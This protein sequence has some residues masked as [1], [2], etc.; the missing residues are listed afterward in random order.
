MRLTRFA[1]VNYLMEKIGTFR[2]T[3][4][5]KF[6]LITGLAVNLRTTTAICF[7]VAWS[8]ATVA[9]FA[10]DN[11]R[12]LG[13]P[14]VKTD[15]DYTALLNEAK[16][17]AQREDF[18][19]AVE[20]Y[21]GL[22]ERGGDVVF[23]S[24]RGLYLPIAEGARRGIAELPE[25][26]LNLYLSLYEPV[27]QRA[28]AEAIESADL[29]ALLQT[30]SQYS[31]TASAA[32]AHYMAGVYY[33]DRGEFA[34]A[35]RYF[36]KALASPR[37]A[38]VNAALARARLAVALS[39]LSRADELAILEKETAA[40]LPN[41]TI[42]IGGRERS[43]VE[44]IK[45]QIAA[46][47]AIAGPPA[48]EPTEWRMQGGNPS[49][50]KLM[51]DSEFALNPQWVVPFGD[52]SYNP[53]QVAQFRQNF[54]MTQETELIPPALVIGNRVIV[55][56]WDWLYDINAFTGAREKERQEAR[57]DLSPNPQ[58]QIYDTNR[59][60]ISSDGAR[61][62]YLE[63]FPIAQQ[64]GVM[65]GGRPQPPAQARSNFLIARD[66]TTYKIVWRIG[67]ADETDEWLRAAIFVT[68]PTPSEGRLFALAEAFQSLHLVCLDA[69]TGRVLWKSYLSSL[70]PRA[71]SSGMYGYVTPL[72]N[73]PPAVSGDSVV[74]ITNGGILASFDR[75]TG[76]VRWVVQYPSTF[77]QMPEAGGR[78]LGGRMPTPVR[79]QQN[80]LIIYND[81]IYALPADSD[82]VAAYD[83]DTGKT[84]WS[85][86]RGT[87]QYLAGISKD[88]L[89]LVGNEAVCLAARDGKILWRTRDL[90]GIAQGRPAMSE[91]YLYVSQKDQGVARVDLANGSTTLLPLGS[92]SSPLG[93]LVLLKDKLIVT[94][95]LG[96]AAYLSYEG[97]FDNATKIIA[98][99]ANDPAKLPELYRQRAVVSFNCLRYDK[100]I[101]DF[102][103]AADLARAQQQTDPLREY[104]WQLTQAHVQLALKLPPD[105][106]AEQ[107]NLAAAVA[108]DSAFADSDFGARARSEVAFTA[109]IFHEAA[110]NHPHAVAA[111]QE[112]LDSIPE[113]TLDAPNYRVEDGRVITG[114]ARITTKN[115]DFARQEIGRLIK[116][117]GA[118]IYAAQDAAAKQLRARAAAA[119]N[120]PQLVEVARRYPFSS[121]ADGALQDAA[122]FYFKAQNYADAEKML[123]LWRARYQPSTMPPQLLAALALTYEN[124]KRDLLAR[125]YVARL[126]KHPHDR[127]IQFAN[128]RGTVGNFLQTAAQRLDLDLTRL[129]TTWTDLPGDLQLPLARGGSQQRFNQGGMRQ[130]LVDT[131]STPVIHNDN[132]IMLEPP[133][134]A[135]IAALNPR[136][137]EPQWKALAD[138]NPA[139]FAVAR[140]WPP[141]QLIS[142]IY[143]DMLV[144]A[145]RDK[146]VGI[147]AQSGKRQWVVP[148]Q[149]PAQNASAIFGVNHVFAT[150]QLG[151]ITAIDPVGGKRLWE[152]A[153]RSPSNFLQIETGAEHIAVIGHSQVATNFIN[154]RGGAPAHPRIINVAPQPRAGIGPSVTVVTCISTVTGKVTGEFRV[155]SSADT[156]WHMTENDQLI[157]QG[158]NFVRCYSPSDGKVLWEAGFRDGTPRLL[159][160]SEEFAICAIDSQTKQDIVA[161]DL[162]SGK[163]RWRRTLED[164]GRKVFAITAVVQRDQVVILGAL[165]TQ[166]ISPQGG[167][168]RLRRVVNQQGYTVQGPRLA[169]IGLSDGGARHVSKLSANVD[170]INWQWIQS[171]VVTENQ[172]VT[173]VKQQM[174]AT[175][176]LACVNDANSGAL[177]QEISVDDAG[178]NQPAANQP[179][180][181]LGGA[182]IIRI[183]GMVGNPQGFHSAGNAAVANGVL[184]IE[185][186]NDIVTFGSGK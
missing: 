31:L 166:N 81:A 2:K 112:I 16:K 11:E 89:V 105:Q 61:V 42:K 45:E 55:R 180:A 170:D 28:V 64:A 131:E 118:T 100:A 70:P 114:M 1:P 47:G 65:W 158:S 111:L 172:I 146:V 32:R 160:A 9:A 144:V 29:A 113:V 125:R 174:G 97:A 51:A 123:S 21:Q 41:A 83:L 44:F 124:Q 176:I 140:Q 98:A 163:I 138:F 108:K 145:D 84:L 147:N 94:T 69:E 76:D 25:K 39:R 173:V 119:N 27:A 104:L 141:Q 135:Q 34:L 74:C 12:P 116:A 72:P 10:Q 181:V 185:G 184:V 164:K 49:G 156:Q 142:K 152:H 117:H 13:L 133:P 182:A 82:T 85:V 56:T 99:A 40:T 15:S 62:F 183:G 150:D 7:A 162:E 58:Q 103:K 30:A 26:G 48:D 155:E 136:T 50:T 20:L 71:V 77:N 52:T 80:P 53:Q 157:L 127:A 60:G 86:E 101:E 178:G 169:A 63:R 38:Q 93:S 95:P 14:L 165:A 179:A 149:R 68:A 73:T 171:P 109:A 17:A 4:R 46:T 87:A 167:V 6:C 168:M 175:K 19:D 96:V 54:G 186:S 130:L 78:F 107:L 8:V 115:S 134:N 36:R 129:K 23:E 153:G 139:A 90:S 154:Q 126:N 110:K 35:A 128:Y 59:W 33:F 106:A 43:L 66:L 161:I 102:R 24:S 5:H 122:E 120:I 3:P 121:S 67:G 22:I 91:K 143:E 92:P 79:G 159:V 132:I 148:V 151:K 137:L 177:L 37:A 57:L 18:A 88:R 75:S